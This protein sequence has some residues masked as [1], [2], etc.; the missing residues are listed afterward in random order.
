M[1]SIE[2]LGNVDIERFKYLKNLTE[3]ISIAI[4]WNAPLY[5]P[6]EDLPQTLTIHTL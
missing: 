2:K 3:L 6:Q 4:K 5:F 1:V